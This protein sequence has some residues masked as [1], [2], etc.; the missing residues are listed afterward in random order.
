MKEKRLYQT[1]GFVPA[2][3]IEAPLEPHNFIRTDIHSIMDP[4]FRR[5]KKRNVLLVRPSGVG[6]TKIASTYGKGVILDHFENDAL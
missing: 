1:R 2:S 4:V 3:D 5:H 6:K